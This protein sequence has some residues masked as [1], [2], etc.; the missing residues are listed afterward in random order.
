M[1]TKVRLPDELTKIIVELGFEGNSEF[2]EEA[3][4]G[5]ILELKKQKFLHVS[6]KILN[7]LKAKSISHEE[8]IEDFEKQRE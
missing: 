1:E 4:R 2:I 8:V 6:D 7:G 3:V 5:K